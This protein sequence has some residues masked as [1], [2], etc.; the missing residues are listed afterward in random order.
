MVAS[1]AREVRPMSEIA[2]GTEVRLIRAGDDSDQTAQTPGM[3]RRV[4]IDINS[5]GSQRLWMARATA[6]PGKR[7]APA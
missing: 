7:S 6:P 3:A 5:T 2:S 4:G 1:G